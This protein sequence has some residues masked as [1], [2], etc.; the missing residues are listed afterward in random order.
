MLDHT[1]PHAQK[2]WAW[3]GPGKLSLLTQPLTA[4]QA[5]E[6]IVANHIIGLNPVDWKMIERGHPTWQ[7]GHVPGVDGMGV[8][9]ARGADVTLPLGDRVAYHQS[10]KYDGSF[11][12]YTRIAAGALLQVPQG[13]ADDLAAAL[14]CP[15]LTAWQAQAKVPDAANRDVL[16]TG[17]GGAV[18]LFLVQLAVERGWRVWTTAAPQHHA[19][20]SALGVSGAFDYHD[21]YWRDA[22]KAALGERRLYAV[23]DTVSGE[24]ARRL[25]SL[26]GYNGHLV[27]IQDRLE[28]A[29]L[30]AFGTAISCHEVALNTMHDHAS[31]QDWQ[32][33]RQAGRNLLAKLRDGTLSTPALYLD[34]F[35]NL[36]Q[37]LAAVKA[38]KGGK[39]LIRASQ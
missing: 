32:Q 21:S 7:P 36:P 39:W 16:V 4:P 1:I 34:D 22:L 38:G 5:D 33:I 24:H 2:V 19:K 10:L 27:C 15:G 9:V 37:A 29:P 14:P 11:A 25:S 20:L 8:I 30:P 23:F 3:Q 6:V 17:A 18:G 12:P 31:T 35:G 26:L 13:V 28:Q